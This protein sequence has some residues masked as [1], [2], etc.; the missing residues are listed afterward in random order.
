MLC[1]YRCAGHGKNR[2][3][4]DGAHEGAFAGHVG[5]ADEED[6]RFVAD[7]DVVADTLC[8]W[9]EGMTELLGVEAGW[10]FEELREWV[11]GVLEAV[12]GEGEEGFDF[13]DCCKPGPDRG[14]VGCAPCLGRIGDLNHVE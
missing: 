1:A 9:D 14:P 2:V 3:D 11:G 10:A 13:A 6:F 4:T 12:S 5:A 8:G 7:A